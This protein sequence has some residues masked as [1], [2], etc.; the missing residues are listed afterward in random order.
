[1]VMR[2][3]FIFLLLTCFPFSLF[4]QANTVTTS[5]NGPDTMLFING[6]VMAV[7]VL[8]TS[9]ATITIEK[10]NS[11]KHKKIEVDREHVF[12]IKYA[13]SGKE[14]MI[15]FYDT[16]V[17]H[18][19]TVEEARQFIA[20]EQDAQRGYR[21]IGACVGAFTV[22][23]ASGVVFGSFIAF[24]PPMLYSGL[25]SVPAIHIRHKSVSNMDNVKKDPYLYGYD[26]A[27]R[28]KRTLRSLVWGGVGLVAGLV[29]NFTGADQGLLNAIS[30]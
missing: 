27:G 8:D 28:R 19:F 1:M 17:G 21:A 7:H 13:G 29:L 4:A 24:A 16:L 15:Y 9:G 5:S 25:M 12:S 22:G 11:K 20:G 10:W 18:D 26:L 30:K 6:K 3:I 2:G 23:L 14:V